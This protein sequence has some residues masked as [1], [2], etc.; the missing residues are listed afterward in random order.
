MA[1]Q[2]SAVRSLSTSLCNASLFMLM[3][4]H[5]LWYSTSSLALFWHAFVSLQCG[6]C[7]VGH[8]STNNII[9]EHTHLNC[10]V[11]CLYLNFSWIILSAAFIFSFICPAHS[12]LVCSSSC[13]ACAVWS[14]LCIQMT[15]QWGSSH[16]TERNDLQPSTR[17]NSQVMSE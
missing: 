14:C 3:H 15:T 2:S 9:E 7:E 12:F 4:W 16:R 17:T 6:L 10:S 8:V 1:T 5:L 13:R 11:L